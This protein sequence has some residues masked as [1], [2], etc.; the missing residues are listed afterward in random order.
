MDHPHGI[1]ERK[2]IKKHRLF[3]TINLNPK[4]GSQPHVDV[5]GGWLQRW[6]ERFDSQIALYIFRYSPLRECG[7]IG[8]LYSYRISEY[9][10]RKF[11]LVRSYQDQTELHS[12]LLIISSFNFKLPPPSACGQ[13]RR[14]EANAS[15]ACIKSWKIYG[16]KC[17]Y[18]VCQFC[19]VIQYC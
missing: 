19:L 13:D 15:L 8:G 12:L 16:S 17:F 1:C 6:V 10:P 5:G 2:E 7:K 18:Q 11:S 9:I 4:G 14:R 3:Q